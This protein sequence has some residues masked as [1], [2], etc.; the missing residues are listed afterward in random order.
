MIELIDQGSEQWKMLRVGRVTASRIADVMSKLK[1]GAESSSRRDYKAQLVAEILTGKPCEDGYI[2]KYMEWGI[3]QE[4]FARALY[5]VTCGVLVDKVAFVVHPKLERCG[6][7][8]D[9]LVDT[10]GLCEIKCPKTATHLQYLIDDV[11]PSEYVKQMQWQMA[12]T[13]RKWCDFVSFDPRLP[14]EHRLFVKRLFRD[15]DLIA[16][17]EVEAVKFLGEVDE[18]IKSLKKRL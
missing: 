11:V 15:K 9:G 8:P 18:V 4:P 12:C 6:C 3:E 13:G 17:M 10:D 1:S 5:E 16:E 7:S 2:N 14:E